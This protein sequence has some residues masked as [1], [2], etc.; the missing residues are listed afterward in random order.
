MFKYLQRLGK[1]LMLPVA[2]LPVASLLMG[3]G[4]YI[5]PAGWG[6]NS[7]IAAF[8]IQTG[9]IVLDNIPIL[10]AIGVGVGLSK[11]RDG[12]VALASL[13]AFLIVTKLLSPGVLAQIT[14]SEVDPAFN[15]INNAFVG[16]VCGA[17]S[18][19]LYNRFSNTKLPEWLAFFS[20]RRLVPIITSVVMILVSVVL[21]YIWPILFNG[22]TQLGISIVS[23]GAFGAGLFGLFNRL[24]IPFGLHH[25]LNQVFW[26]DLIGINDI[27]RFWGDAAAAYQGLP[28]ALA[29]TSYKVGMYQ[30]GWFPVMMFGLPGAALA[31]ILTSKKKNRG[32]VTSL[33]LA[34]IIAAFTTGVTEP[35]EFTFMF[36]APVLFLVHAVLAAISMAVVALIG[37]TAGFGFSAGLIDYVLS[38]RN[39]NASNP[40]LLIL[41]GLVFFVVYFVVFYVMIKAF[42]LKTPGR[43]DEDMETVQEELTDNAYAKKAVII[44]EGVGGASN[45]LS[46]DNCATRLR[47]EIKNKN[48]ID[49][50]KIKKSGAIDTIVIGDNSVQV[51]V[52]T[53]VQFVAD[54]F[55][56][57]T[58]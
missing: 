36:L 28:E 6:A 12:A 8:L 32:V 30:A 33:M 9:A 31:M 43:D 44:L 56:K 11:D 26:F 46:V 42:N 49:K 41:I 29:N 19:G 40:L 22:L 54:E 24:L 23:L 15:K 20:G 57:L 39:P 58:K 1:S 34:G 55:K 37:T 48:L 21:Y 45:V 53:S 17:I 4:Y 47:L 51:I 52:G 18:A 3:I 35:I 5:D 14:G 16:I 25:T 38:L 10:F 27:G 7:K 50:K 2:V 13:V